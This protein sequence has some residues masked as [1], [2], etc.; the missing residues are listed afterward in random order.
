MQASVQLHLHRRERQSLVTSA[1][2][3]GIQSLGGA[4]FA[5][6]ERMD[7][8]LRATLTVLPEHP[9]IL[10]VQDIQLGLSP[11]KPRHMH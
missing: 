8:I 1:V 11:W 10:H 4:L 6:E 2:A 5:H 7:L 9:L 3:R